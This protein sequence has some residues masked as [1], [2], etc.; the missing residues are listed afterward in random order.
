MTEDFMSALIRWGVAPERYQAHPFPFLREGVTR[1]IRQRG[2]EGRLIVLP[3]FICPVLVEAV[4]AGGAIPALVDVDPDTWLLDLESARL[5]WKR[6]AAVIGV[7]TLGNPDDMVQLRE[8]MLRL[9]PQACLIEDM[10]HA[11]LAKAAGRTLSCSGDVVLVSLYK[12]LPHPF[13]GVVLTR[14]D[15]RAIQPIV[16]EGLTAHMNLGSAGYPPFTAWWSP[17]SLVPEGLADPG[18]LEKW[19]LGQAAQ[20][21]MG[22]QGQVT[23]RAERMS[24]WT[25]Q[26]PW[27]KEAKLQRPR[28]ETWQSSWY[29]LS[30]QLTDRF[31]KN[32]NEVVSAL[33]REGL[34]ADR[35]WWD[36]PVMNPRYRPY[37]MGFC[38]VSRRLAQRVVNVH[39][40]SRPE[41]ETLEKI[42]RVFSA[43]IC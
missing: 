8:R 33:R 34:L 20:S 13:G 21:L 30:W 15:G 25:D 36:A 19:M 28:G 27:S 26:E 22:L 2:W 39:W 17:H 16:G 5:P 14:S 42:S 37:V 11:L 32:L 10:A 29:A 1:L 3:A 23:R 40:G 35:L 4:L 18:I 24:G 6:V 7:H 41:A 9:A 12:Q 43:M 31:P 38:S